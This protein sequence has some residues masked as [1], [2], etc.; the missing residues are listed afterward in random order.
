M[1]VDELPNRDDVRCR[2]PNRDDVRFWIPN[3]DDVRLWTCSPS[4]LQ[5]WLHALA[6]V[7]LRTLLS[8]EILT[9]Y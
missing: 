1:A 3:R 5:D 7:G 2:I 8:S 6:C 4:T 9:N